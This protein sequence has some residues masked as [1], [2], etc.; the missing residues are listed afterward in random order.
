MYVLE[1]K[2]EKKAYPCEPQFYYI[3]EGFRGVSISWTCFPDV[4]QRWSDNV[5]EVN[6]EQK[7][8]KNIFL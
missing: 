3:K 8:C 2:Y 4:N 1:Q 6:S 7:Y 5:W